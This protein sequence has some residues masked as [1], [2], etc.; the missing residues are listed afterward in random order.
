MPYIISTPGI[1]EQNDNNYGSNLREKAL[2]INPS[3]SQALGLLGLISGLKDEH[4]VSNVL[5]KQAHLLQ[6]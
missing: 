2:E 6:T 3:N 4:S 5:F 1:S